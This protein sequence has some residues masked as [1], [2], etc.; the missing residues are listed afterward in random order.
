MTTPT[1][2]YDKLIDKIEEL[3]FEL[4]DTRHM[5]HEEQE[6]HRLT[7]EEHEAYTQHVATIVVE[8]DDAEE[9]LKR[10][11]QKLENVNRNGLKKDI[12]AEVVDITED[13]RDV[14]PRFDPSVVDPPTDDA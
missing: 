5:L 8:R 6:A 14:L 2:R 9:R 3:R 10:L 1:E 4:R 7:R 13:A 11:R 12:V